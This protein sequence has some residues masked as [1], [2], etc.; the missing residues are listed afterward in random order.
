MRWASVGNRRRPR[1][2]FRYAIVLAQQ[3]S[4]VRG[5]PDG[6]AGNKRLVVERLSDQH[7]AQGQQQCG[8]GTRLNG[9][10]LGVGHRAEVIAHRTDIDK[11][12]AVGLHLIQP[13]LEHMVIG[14][15]AVDLGIAQR[16]SADGDKQLTLPGQLGKMGMLLGAAGSAAR[17]YAAEYARPRRCYRYWCWRCTRQSP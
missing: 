9:Q 8:I 11:P 10:P 5:K 17:E 13:V 2:G 12:G 3:I 15:A 14:A 7:I 4:A 1:R 6:M 16:Q